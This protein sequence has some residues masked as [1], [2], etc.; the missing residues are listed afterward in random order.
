MNHIRVLAKFSVILLLSLLWML[1]G[2]ANCGATV[3]VPEHLKI[4]KIALLNPEPSLGTMSTY[5]QRYAQVRPQVGLI[6][7]NPNG[8]PVELREIKDKGYDL[9]V[10]P[11]VRKR[12]ICLDI[13]DLSQNRKLWTL[14]NILPSAELELLFAVLDRALIAGIKLMPDPVRLGVTPGKDGDLGVNFSCGSVLRLLQQMPNI[15]IEP[16]PLKTFNDAKGK[17]VELCSEL[18]LDYI[19]YFK[20]DEFK[21]TRP[22]ITGSILKS[23]GNAHG[24]IAMRVE[25]NSLGL[26]IDNPRYSSRQ[27]PVGRIPGGVGGS[28]PVNYK[29]SEGTRTTYVENNYLTSV[30]E[31]VSNYLLAV[32]LT[33]FCCPREEPLGI[34]LAPRRKYVRDGAYDFP[35]LDDPKK[36]EKVLQFPL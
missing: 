2:A 31:E 17:T 20:S 21:Y 12:K 16:I 10:I 22:L 24:D 14:Y 27:S 18:K 3:P 15:Q 29:D 34:K 33:E 5:F 30:A 6:P 9:A 26:I 19:L 7:F 11:I 8:K 25:N 13:Y 28:D 23:D 1:L 32:L 4:Q 35:K 36:A